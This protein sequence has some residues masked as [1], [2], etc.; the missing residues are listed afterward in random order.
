MDIH[1]LSCRDSQEFQVTCTEAYGTFRGS[2]KNTIS[3]SHCNG[4]DET[5]HDAR[6]PLMHCGEALFQAP[7]SPDYVPGPEEPEQAPPPPELVPEPIYPEFM[8]PKNDVLP[9]EEQPLL[10]VVSPTTDS[11]GCIAEFDPE[12]DPKEEDDEDPADYPTNRHDDDE[13]EK[14][15]GDDAD[16]EEEDED[17]DG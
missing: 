9:A 3:G 13:E 14:S 5:A 7:P 6:G 16:D 15:F 2:V 10:V 11:S 8:P 1:I 4:Y 12:E 17:E